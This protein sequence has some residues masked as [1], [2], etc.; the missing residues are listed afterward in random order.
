MSD[1]LE[2][3]PMLHEEC[4]HNSTECEPRN[5]VEKTVSHIS[6]YVWLLTISAGISG[7]LFGYDTGVISSVLVGIHKS[8]GHPLSTWEKSLITSVTALSALIV[9]PLSG[10]LADTFGRK[11]VI[12]LTDFVFILGVLTQ[13]L[14]SSV[15]G[16]TVGR[17]I[18]GLAIG[19]GSFVAP[20]YITE[21]SPSPFRGR[22]V[23]IY[24]LFI[25]IGQVLAFLVGWIFVEL[26]N[27]A[28]GWR[29][30]VGLGALPALAQGLIM[31]AMPETPRWLVMK[32]RG[33]KA[34]K[35]LL[36]IFGENTDTSCV[37]DRVLRGIEAEAREKEAAERSI[38][39]LSEMKIRGT[40]G[41]FGAKATWSELINRDGNRRALTIACLLQGLQQLCGINSIVYFSATIFTNLDFESPNL[42]SLIVT[43]TNSLF[44]CVAFSLIDRVGR[45]RILLHSLPV[46]AMGLILCSLAFGNF[47]VPQ[48]QPF[49]GSKFAR[50]SE[51]QSVEKYSSSV[52]RLIFLASISLYV[53][54]YAIGL[55]TVP[56]LQSELF[57]LPVR[58]LGSSLSTGTNWTANFIV[59]LTFLPMMEIL[60]PS[61]TFIFYAVICLLGWLAIWHFY[62]ET[63][64]KVLEEVRA[65][66]NN[67]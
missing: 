26:N 65:L 13:A 66:A 18:V 30:V 22:L 23:I 60:T 4:H 56:W 6:I 10:L 41:L 50:S 25:T 54:A 52:G 40:S 46:M 8:L 35:I 62:P 57:P 38:L 2:Q 9:S 15:G 63:M 58:A 3:S 24:V 29:W 33:Q 19:T 1:P 12:L 20:L 27:S 47:T 64:G 39:A 7:L 5:D 32:K 55:G 28:T 34:R 31:V 45:R 16:M 11:M 48:S 14:T 36:R 43:S 61:G 37:A 67:P 59:S 21:L 17:F 42:I 51:A 49:S 44:T 53:G